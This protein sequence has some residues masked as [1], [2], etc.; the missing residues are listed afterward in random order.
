MTSQSNHKL[1]LPVAILINI[2]IMLGTGI[3]VNTALLAKKAG[4]LGALGYSI[5]GL[6]MLPLVISIT[7]LLEIHPSGGFYIFGQKEIHPL[8][9]FISA[10]T[11]FTGK[12]ASATFAIH[13][14]VL[15]TQSV[16]TS[17]NT[18][19]PLYLDAIILALFIALNMLHIRTGG[20]IQTLFIVF[21]TIPIL[22][23]LLV[24]SFFVQGANFTAPHLLWHG[25]PSILPLVLFAIA[26]FEAACSISSNIENAR[27]NA[28]RA[29]LISYGTVIGIATLFQ[30]IFY[31]IHG[32]LFNTFADY[33]KAFPLFVQK[34][35]PNLPRLQE[36]I[37][38]ILHLGIAMSALGG[39]YGILFSN[40]WNLYT[41]A[42]HH[43]VIGSS[44]LSR[45]NTYHIPWLCVLFEGLVGTLY[46]AITQ[47]NQ[48]PLQQ[49]GA[50][51]S[52]TAYTISAL[53]LWYACTNN[54]A[55]H[56]P[57]WLPLLGLTNC[58][59]LTASCLYNLYYSGPTSLILFSCL[60]FMGIC[61]FFYTRE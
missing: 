26:G 36:V 8:A 38:G 47:G 4:A 10:W 20:K 11:Y 2:N 25:I 6:L 57:S 60:C 56:I 51:G 46:I 15:L 14:A 45:L 43:H 39:S 19:N 55:A 41:L 7:R 44:Y 5:V 22:F 1:T 28:P 23:L 61:M 49:M 31:G 12:L 33:R 9:G 16:I 29:V 27:V 59:M 35:I 3:F 32:D 24:G 50:L 34:V 17:L 42:R 37:S 13:T 18:I 30:L 21:K 58:L 54:R 40:S 52:V 48:L 53:S